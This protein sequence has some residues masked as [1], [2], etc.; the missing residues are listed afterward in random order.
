MKFNKLIAGF[1]DTSLEFEVTGLA[2][3]SREVKSGDVFIALAGAKQHGLSYAPQAIKQGAAAIIYAPEDEGEKL[4]TQLQGIS[5]VKIENLAF[6]LADIAARFYDYPVKKLGVIGLTGTNGKTSCSQFLAQMLD[7][8]AVIGTLG[9]GKWGQL[10][11]TIN[12]T[13]DALALQKMLAECVSKGIETL[14]MEVSSH[15]LE[16][17]RVNGIDFTGA[18]F[19]NLSRDHLDYHGSMEAYFQAKLAL[20]KKPELEFAVINLDDA[21]SERIIASL[22]ENVVLWIFSVSGKTLEQAHCVYAQHI[23]L[24]NTG[25]SFEVC[26]NK[27][28]V[29]VCC[30]IYGG[31]NVENILAAITTLLA[32]GFSLSEAAA[33]ASKL[34]TISGRMQCFGGKGQPLVFVDYAHTPDAL[35]KASMALKQHQH[36]AVS[37][38]F[39]CGGDRDQ[40]KRALMGQVACEHADNIIIT[41]DNPRTENGDNIIQDILTGCN[42]NKVNVIRDRKQAIEK[43]ITQAS[44]GDCVLIAGKGHEDYQEINDVK[45]PF[46]DVVIV[47]QVLQARKLK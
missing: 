36:D 16:Q 23:Q 18:I 3:D 30:D 41:D 22:V 17:G 45:Y 31:F 5:L 27:D 34:E 43:A 7:N 44:S 46:S 37:L 4:A 6:K 47:Q 13:P 28:A 38:V 25:L 20:F 10:K 32:M 15:G 33:K 8:S 14:A 12:T 2:L 19:T 21:Y 39:G 24:I 35:A 29:T 26:Y 11:T 40:G 1:V 42:S 9:W